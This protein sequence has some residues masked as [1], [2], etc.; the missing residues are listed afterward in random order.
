MSM[1]G[2]REGTSTAEG[3]SNTEELYNSVS[4]EAIGEF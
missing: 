3:P 2:W 1:P 4:E